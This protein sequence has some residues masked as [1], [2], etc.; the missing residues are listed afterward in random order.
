M[1]PALAAVALAVALAAALAIG[2]CGRKTPVRPPEAV[3]PEPITD[4]RATNT[5][6]GIGLAW[7]RPTEAADG[8]VLFDL[9]GFVVERAAGGG[10]YVF[11]TRLAVLDRNKLR[12]QRRFRYTDTTA[13]TGEVYRYRVRAVTV[14]GY[15]SLDSNVV[16]LVRAVPTPT[17]TTALPTATAAPAP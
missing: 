9:D 8:A 2:A 17:P 12:Q 6:A 15:E 3:A 5:T 13:E 11:L 16:E 4:L 10:P 14:D 1:R 7:R